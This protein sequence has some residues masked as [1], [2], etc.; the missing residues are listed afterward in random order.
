MEGLHNPEESQQPH[1][2]CEEKHKGSSSRTR[3]WFTRLILTTLTHLDVVRIE[4]RLGLPY[5]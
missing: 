2:E 5:N 1:V 3:F 4:F